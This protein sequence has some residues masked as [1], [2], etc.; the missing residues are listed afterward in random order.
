[1]AEFIMKDLVKKAGLE[2]EFVIDSR[3]TQ[4]RGDGESDSSWDYG[5][6]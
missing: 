3:A 2:Q 4:Y 5:D 1:M 6:F